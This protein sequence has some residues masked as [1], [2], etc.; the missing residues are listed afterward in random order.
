MKIAWLTNN[1]N[2]LGGIEQVICGLSSYFSA[3]L[4]HDVEIVSINSY[5]S[6]VFYSLDASVKVRHCGLDW[7]KQTF[8][9]LLRLVGSIMSEL[10]ADILLTCHPSISYAAV[11]NKRKFRGKVIVTEHISYDFYSKKRFFCNTVFFRFADQFVVLTNRDRDI[12]QKSGCS[13]IVIPNANFCPTEVRSSLEE[14]L[15]LAAGRMEQVKGFDRLIEAFSKV[16]EKHPNWKLCICGSG[17]LEEQLRMQVQTLGIS[18][19]VLLPGTVNNM[20]DYYRNA[21]IFTLSSHC[22]GFPLVLVEAISYGLPMC[23]FEIPSTAEIL[24]NG[25][26]ILVPQDDV[27]AFAKGLDRLM[28]DSSLR[29]RLSNEAYETSKKYTIPNIAESWMQLF[30]NLAANK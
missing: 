30:H 10:D 9:Q 12:Y 5:N 17:S 16:A 8:S 26:G 1:I 21:S 23:V 6:N 4:N 14:K 20:Q 19:Q 22:E 7:R 15:I 11:L 18:E 28:S 13:A 29:S 24:A 25:G 3:E 27:S 2:Q